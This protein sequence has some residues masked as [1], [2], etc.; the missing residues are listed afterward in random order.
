[1]EPWVPQ[2]PFQPQ[3][4]PMVPSMDTNRGL[5]SGHY[6]HHPHP[7]YSGDKYHQWQEAHRNSKPQQDPRTQDP[8]AQDLRADHQEAH[9]VPRPGEWSQPVS[10]VDYLGGPY[11]A[12]LY[13]RY[14]F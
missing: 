3:G 13:S 4:R 2:R 1:M 12:Q 11:P 14:D 9:Y 6:R 8:R 5:Q 7:Q 10:G